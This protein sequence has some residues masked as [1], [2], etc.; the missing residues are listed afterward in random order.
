MCC[1]T[2]AFRMSWL[3]GGWHIDNHVPGGLYTADK[4]PSFVYEFRGPTIFLTGATW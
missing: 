2:I 3:Y 1:T 4:V